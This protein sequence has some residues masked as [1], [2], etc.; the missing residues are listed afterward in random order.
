MAK[1]GNRRCETLPIL[2]PDAAGIDIGAS[3]LYVSVG[4]IAIHNLSAV[5]PHSPAICMR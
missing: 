3:G 4:A 2:H 5:S 1:N